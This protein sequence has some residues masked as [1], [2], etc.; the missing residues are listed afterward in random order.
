V[1]KSDRRCANTKCPVFGEATKLFVCRN[2]H[3]ATVLSIYRPRVTS[4]RHRERSAVS[5]PGV[6]AHLAG[7][8]G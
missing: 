2:C 8:A 7:K 3:R 5:S 1:P 4:R 6:A